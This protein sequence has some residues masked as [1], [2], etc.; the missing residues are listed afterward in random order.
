MVGKWDFTY[1]LHLYSPGATEERKS[2]V[3]QGR[4]IRHSSMYIIY[5][6]YIIQ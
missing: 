1:H 3:P 4:D 5:I 6:I 2:S